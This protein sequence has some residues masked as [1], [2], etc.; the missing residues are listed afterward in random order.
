M[1]NL[2]NKTLYIAGT[3]IKTLSHITEEVKQA[4]SKCDKTLYLVNEPLLKQYI[5]RVSKDHFD[6]EEIYFSFENR[7]DS[8]H[9]ITAHILDT[10][11]YHSSLTLI[12]Y[13]HPYF[14]A[15]P[16][17]EAGR[18]A[19]DL[20]CNVLSMPGISS[21]DCLFS[22]L[23][24]D[25]LSSGVQLYEATQLIN[26]DKVIDT[27]LNLILF[28]VGFIN[29]KNHTHTKL[30]ND[31]YAYLCNYLINQYPATHKVVLYE[32]SLYPSVS[33]RIENHTIS[34]ITECTTTSISTFYIPGI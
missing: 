25:P 6:L 34:N 21:I 17:L 5:E 19:K 26:S 15:S 30:S 4:I 12:A 33:P 9:Q 7:A 24:I 14:C 18:K 27:S 2:S 20:G 3:G 13:G 32:A 10:L 1:S 23:M 31:S 8:Y 16:F 29:L 22:D 11:K 28:Q